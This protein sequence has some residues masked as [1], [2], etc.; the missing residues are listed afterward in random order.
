MYINRGKYIDNF[1]DRDLEEVIRSKNALRNTEKTKDSNHNDKS[2][3]NKNI[4]Y[5]K[6]SI[7][8]FET[9]LSYMLRHEIPRIK[10]IQGEPYDVLVQWLTVL[11][12]VCSY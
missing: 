12:K 3:V 2:F 7:V 6:L 1:D 5:Q 8:D 4:L 9:A 11:I 10:V